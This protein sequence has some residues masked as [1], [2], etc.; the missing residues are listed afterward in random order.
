VSSERLTALEKLEQGVKRHT[1][2]QHRHW[3]AALERMFNS[4]LSVFSQMGSFTNTGNNS[5]EFVWLLLVTKAFNSLRWAYQLLQVGYYGQALTL[6]RS[7][8][9]DWLVCMDCLGHPDT[10][11]AILIKGGR[12]PKFE[13]MARRLDEPLQNWWGDNSQQ[14]EG[15]YGLLSTF[16]HPRY[17]AIA[18]LIDPERKDL[19]LGP[20]YDKTMFLFTY[21]YLA[22]AQVRMT[23][24]LVRCAVDTPA[25]KS[26]NTVTPA[27]NGVLSCSEQVLEQAE[28]LLRAEGLST[29]EG[30]S[31]S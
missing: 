16:A 8:Y 12:L 4:Y 21:N 3:L 20:Q 11:R 5:R 19:R 14:I 22:I 28:Q 29:P 7:A 30:G 24:F 26:E 2:Q 25:G 18:T 9:E 23:E 15:T 17:R 31:I 1:I 6:T 10:V 27:V 13:T